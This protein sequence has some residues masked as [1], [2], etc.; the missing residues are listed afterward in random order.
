M[1]VLEKLKDLDSGVIVK[2]TL[3]RYVEDKSEPDWKQETE[4]PLYIQRDMTG[5]I[6][7]ITPMNEAWAEYGPD[8]YSDVFDTFENEGYFMKVTV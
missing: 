2:Y 3:G 6:V 1:S 7:I 5:N 8:D 4:G